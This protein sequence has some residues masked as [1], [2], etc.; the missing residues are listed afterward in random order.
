M[1][2]DDQIAQIAQVGRDFL[3]SARDTR[4]A[5]DRRAADR[6]AAIDRRSRR[7]PDVAD[8]RQVDRRQDDDA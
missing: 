7:R 1:V 3:N 5:I 8:R 4:A 6:R 2:D